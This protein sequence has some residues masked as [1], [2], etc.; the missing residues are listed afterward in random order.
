MLGRM[1][2]NP[3]N[4]KE[5][6]VTFGD[7]HK[8]MPFSFPEYE[9]FLAD[10]GIHKSQWEELIAGINSEPCNLPTTVSQRD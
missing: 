8:V 10:H 1:F 6:W 4:T 5:I 3:D 7:L 9:P 2:L